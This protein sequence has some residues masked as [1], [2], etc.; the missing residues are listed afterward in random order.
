[1]KHLFILLVS[2]LLC[3]SSCKKDQLVI[4]VEKEFVQIEPKVVLNNP[5]GGGWI[6]KL[7]PGGVA[8]IIPSGDIAYNGTYKINGSSVKV[9]TEQESFIFE[10]ISETNIENKKYGVVL[11]WNK[12]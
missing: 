2:T 12:K 4:D 10:I 1:M 5:Y 8:D 3:F 9:K 6:L 11:K 7:K